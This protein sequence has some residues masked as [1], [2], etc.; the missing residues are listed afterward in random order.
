VAARTSREVTLAKRRI[1]F[2]YALSRYLIGDEYAD[3]LGYPPPSHW[4]HV[5]TAFRT[6][7][8]EAGGRLRSFAPVESMAVEMG[9]RYWQSVTREAL[10]GVPAAFSMP[11]LQA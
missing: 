3:H 5:L 8:L 4:R 7:N 11:D 9:R 2:G 10:R 1:P 6:L